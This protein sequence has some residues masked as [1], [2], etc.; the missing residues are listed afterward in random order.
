MVTPVTGFCSF[1][2]L[3]TKK[4]IFPIYQEVCHSVCLRVKCLV[5]SEVQTV[6]NI[7]N[8]ESQDKCIYFFL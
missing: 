1:T 3:F 5:I 2:G 7:S 6:V 4:K 8:S